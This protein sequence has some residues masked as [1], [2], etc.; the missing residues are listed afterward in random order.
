MKKLENQ[1]LESL[2]SNFERLHSILGAVEYSL[3]PE[4]VFHE[5]NILEALKCI[6][7][8]CEWGS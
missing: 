2:K 4:D 8:D 1:L 7:E 6:V 3:I 5:K